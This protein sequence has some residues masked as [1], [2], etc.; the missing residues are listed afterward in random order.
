M[1]RI[2]ISLFCFLGII[3]PAPVAS[4]LDDD[5]QEG[6]ILWAHKDLRKDARDKDPRYQ[7]RS[8][9]YGVGYPKAPIIHTYNHETFPVPLSVFLPNAQSPK[10]LHEVLSQHPN[11]EKYFSFVVQGMENRRRLRADEIAIVKKV[12]EKKKLTE[13]EEA[14]YKQLKNSYKENNIYYLDPDYALK[15][16]YF[17]HPEAPHY[18]YDNPKKMQLNHEVKWTVIPGS[19]GQIEPKEGPRLHTNKVSTH[20]QGKVMVPYIPFVKLADLQKTNVKEYN[21]VMGIMQKGNIQ[22]DDEGR[23]NMDIIN[24]VPEVKRMKTRADKVKIKPDAAGKVNQNDVERLEGKLTPAEQRAKENMMILSGN[25]MHLKGIRSTESRDAY[26][27]VAFE[28]EGKK[29]SAVTYRWLLTELD[30][31]LFNKV[32]EKAE[33]FR[34][35]LI[36]LAPLD[37]FK[38]LLGELKKYIGELPREEEIPQKKQAPQKEIIPQE[39]KI[40]VDLLKGEWSW[41]SPKSNITI[42]LDGSQNLITDTEGSSQ[43][44]KTFEVGGLDKIEIPYDMNVKGHLSIGVLS[45]DKSRFLAQKSLPFGMQNGTLE[46]PT[47]GQKQ[48]T[49]VIS[50]ELRHQKKSSEATLYKLGWGGKKEAPFIAALKD[51]KAWAEIEKI[52]AEEVKECEDKWD[53]FR[54]DN[55]TRPLSKLYSDKRGMILGV[56]EFIKLGQEIDAHLLKNSTDE[57]AKK[58]REINEKRIETSIAK[59]EKINSQIEEEEK[60]LP[61]GKKEETPISSGKEEEKSKKSK[62][63]GQ[64]LLPEPQPKK[65]PDNKK[66]MILGIDPQKILKEDREVKRAQIQ[67]EGQNYFI[68]NVSTFN[69]NCGFN[70]LDTTREEVQQKL[71]ALRGK[72][73]NNNAELERV[74]N[75]GATIDGIILPYIGHYVLDANVRVFLIGPE[76]FG[77][78]TMF[79]DVDPQKLGL[80]K[81]DRPTINVLNDGQGH[82][83]ILVSTEKNERNEILRTYGRQKED[84]QIGGDQ[85][86]QQLFNLQ[87]EAFQKTYADITH[88][89]FLNEGKGGWLKSYVDWLKN[90]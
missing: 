56:F 43:F 66:P 10:A 65:T 27:F 7:G 84:L 2:L 58:D 42:N 83:Q 37:E 64:D 16:Q 47:L 63:K 3:K 15:P 12:E 25:V 23:V 44:K 14:R 53:R 34:D 24:G 48:V 67:S 68:Y 88:S 80:Y 49:L 77:V 50:N 21:R 85:R 8:E 89:Q 54:K 81:Q 26:D 59:I 4:F 9:L 71:K 60:K 18:L 33:T 61:L 78:R 17:V 5:L 69:M 55:A 82:F 40:G 86:A 41:Q 19:I 73:G 39:E 20:P 72:L 51:K 11:H 30:L 52:G 29:K 79:L 76:E 35:L 46:V 45:E 38:I 1:K 28:E 75:Q 74:W 70:T 57:N 31:E 62:E 36:G 13:G 32:L 87:G 90:K 22:A 6:V